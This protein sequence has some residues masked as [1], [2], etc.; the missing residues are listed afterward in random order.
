LYRPTF[1]WGWLTG[2]ELQSIITMVG[3]HGIVQAGIALE[4]ELRVLHLDPTAARKGLSP[5]QLRGRSQSP[6]PR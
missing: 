5:R 2:S 3:K 4:K 1:N 6:P